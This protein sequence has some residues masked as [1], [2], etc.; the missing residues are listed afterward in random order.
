MKKAEEDDSL[1]N[2]KKSNS[3]GTISKI[4]TPSLLGRQEMNLYIFCPPPPPQ[5][6]GCILH[7]GALA[8]FLHDLLCNGMGCVTGG[9]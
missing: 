1:N 5:L 8:I 2:R 6:S 3:P 4:P 7:S 9:A